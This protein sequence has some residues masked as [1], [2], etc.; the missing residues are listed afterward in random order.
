MSYLLASPKRRR[1]R[2]DVIAT[3]KAAESMRSKKSASA[4]RLT[5]LSL[6]ET[7]RW[8]KRGPAGVAGRSCASATCTLA[9][10]ACSST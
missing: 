5:C 7:L 3:G 6:M 9:A 8:V 4:S 1:M 10:W 2:T